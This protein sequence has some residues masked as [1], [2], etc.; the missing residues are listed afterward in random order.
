MEIGVKYMSINPIELLKQKVSSVIVNDQT[1]LVNEK[2]AIL[3]RFYPI[4][5]SRFLAN[6]ELIENF[7][8]SYQAFLKRDVLWNRQHIESKTWFGEIMYI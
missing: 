8:K 4:L 6:P 2:N 3:S 1:C 5:L 7:N